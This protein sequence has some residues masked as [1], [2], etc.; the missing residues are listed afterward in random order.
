MAVIL[1]FQQERRRLTAKRGFAGWAK[2]FP[3]SLNEQTSLADLSDTMLRT[4]SQSGEGSSMLIQ[5]LVIRLMGLGKGASFH[6]LEREARLAVMDVSLFLLDQ[7]RFEI[8]RRL[9]WVENSP[10]FR[11]PILD[12]V[13]RF[14]SVYSTMKNHTPDLLRSHP[15]YP[16]YQEAFEG[17][18]SVFVRRLIPDALEA[19]QEEDKG[20]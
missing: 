2:R 11:L 7:M 12:L 5:D 3:D 17:D 4:L 14:P 8:M 13:E 18:R 15:R 9:S 16:E 19:F 10:V 20:A 6:D 1:E